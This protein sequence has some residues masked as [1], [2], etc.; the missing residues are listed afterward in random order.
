MRTIISNSVIFEAGHIILFIIY[1][2]L[3]IIS[4]ITYIFFF[5]QLNCKLLCSIE[6]N[7]IERTHSRSCQ[8]V[9]KHTHTYTHT[10][11][12]NAWWQWYG[13]SSRTQYTYICMAIVAC[14]R[15]QAQ[16]GTTEN[17]VLPTFFHNWTPLTTCRTF[18]PAR[19][20][21]KKISIKFA[22]FI[23]FEWN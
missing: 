2:E 22:K 8:K 17:Q 14:I 18:D 9:T 3:R 19:N 6:I 10:T 12:M 4:L 16:T 5:S 15:Q 11:L 20:K 7:T 1:S 23:W 21:S 13:D